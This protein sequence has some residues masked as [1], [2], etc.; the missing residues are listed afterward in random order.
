V[1][2]VAILH[3]S[4]SAAGCS[5][6]PVAWF[7]S[8][9]PSCKRSLSA[10]SGSFWSPSWSWTWSR[11]SGVPAPSVAEGLL[12]GI[13]TAVKLTPAIFYCYLLMVRKFRA[14]WAAVIC[15]VA[16]TL[17]SAAIMPAASYEFWSRLAHG[18]TGLGHSII[19]YTNQSVMADIVRIF[20][21][22]RTPA[23]VGLV[24]S[25]SSRCGQSGPHA[26]APA[27]RCRLAVNLC[28]VAGLWPHPCPGCTTSSG[29]CRW[30]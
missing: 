27:R 11:T 28:G 18:D 4:D 8:S 25:A 21:L 5:A 3:R 7:M 6:R 9:N 26:V 10:S 14:F 22:G 1:A 16:V 19:Y 15:A 20:G 13:A 12:T 29:W 23:I 24:V 30:P 17:I 2:L